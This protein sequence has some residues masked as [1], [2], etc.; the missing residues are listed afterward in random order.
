MWLKEIGDGSL[1]LVRL[2][3][4]NKLTYWELALDWLKDRGIVIESSGR[5]WS[6]ANITSS[7]GGIVCL[8]K[9]VDISAVTKFEI[10][11]DQVKWVSWKDYFFGAVKLFALRAWTDPKIVKIL[12]CWGESLIIESCGWIAVW[13]RCIAKSMLNFRKPA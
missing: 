7:Y 11:G 4:V 12:P 9:D 3:L 6:K 13:E 2:N 1:E 10:V 5:A 8:S